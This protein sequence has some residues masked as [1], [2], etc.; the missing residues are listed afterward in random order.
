MTLQPDGL[1]AQR[2]KL[3]LTQARL[4]RT[5]GVTANTLARWERGVAPIGNPEVV[6]LALQRLASSRRTQ[7]GGSARDHAVLGRPIRVTEHMRGRSNRLHN[8]PA[9]ISSFVGRSQDVAELRR[10][11]ELHRLITLTGSGG[12][13]KTRLALEVG[14]KLV[15]Q[16]SDG[17]R[18]IELAGLAD[19]DLVPQ[20]VALILGV[21]ERTGSALRD[22]LATALAQRDVLLVLDNC[23]HL[24]DACAGLVEHLLH[25]CPHVSVLATSREP[26]GVQGEVVWLVPSL[27]LPEPNVALPD[28]TSVERVASAEAVQLLVDRVAAVVPRFTVTDQNAASIATICVRLDGIPLALELAAARANVLDVQEIAFR[29]DNRLGL[30]STGNRTA[31]RRHHTLR[32]ALEWSYG[33]LKPDEQ[34]FFDRMSVFAGGWTLEAAGGVCMVEADHDVD[35][36]DMLTALVSKSLVLKGTGARGTTRYRLLEMLR[37]F[38]AEQLALHGEIEAVRDRHAHFY[39]GLSERAESE[40]WGPEALD[41]WQRLDAEN[42]NLRTALR[43]LIDRGDAV[44]AQ[45]LGA[46]LVRFWQTQSYFT[47]GRAWLTELL[48]MPCAQ[49]RTSVRARLLAGAGHLAGFQADF[50]VALRMLGEAVIIAREAGD[51][52]TL[53]AALFYDSEVLWWAGQFAAARERAT[54]GSRIGRSHGHYTLQGMCEYVLGAIHY[55]LGEYGRARARQQESLRLNT[56]GGYARGIAVAHQQ[57][58]RIAYREGQLA[59][60]RRHMEESVA[61]FRAS[62]WPYGIAWDFATLGWIATDQGQHEDARKYLVESLRLFRDLGATARLVECLEG[63]AQLAGATDDF[64]RAQRL[65]GL[66]DAQREALG[67]RLSPGES[68][69]LGPRLRSAQ[70]ALGTTRAATEWAVGRSMSLDEACEYALQSGGSKVRPRRSATPILTARETEVA[71]QVAHGYTNR[72]I[73]ERLVIGERTV[74]THLERIYAKLEIHSRLQLAGWVVEHA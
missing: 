52:L 72:Q 10:L 1:R 74:E 36:L 42:L 7:T 46:S 67:V 20:A 12:V 54:E 44:R 70:M 62:A 37:E 32:A 43:W 9:Q 61:G 40:T 29:L 31:P 56:E 2:L 13:G 71:T 8:L 63:F 30:L 33:L 24:L 35:V 23:E 65:G 59:T 39:L 38:G 69:A 57:L 11:V 25:Q 26:L 14:S 60:A 21:P 47:E 58:G 48:A 22:T 41:R 66:A 50:T 73:A 55:E 49:P 5:L 53:L 16:H 27:G 3:G 4:A 68:V 15:G 34:R 6:G 19:P 18:F 64:V 45:R 28:R 51:D 17:I